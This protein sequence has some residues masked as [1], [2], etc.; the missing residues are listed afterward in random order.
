MATGDLAD[1]QARLDQIQKAYDSGVL[2]V[3]HGDEDTIFRDHDDMARIINSLKK[4]IAALKG[5]TAAPKVNYITQ[6]S[7]GIGGTDSLGDGV[8]VPFDTLTRG[9]E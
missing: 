2:R 6:S 9:F 4:R 5:E 8:A 1:L 3:R 7:K